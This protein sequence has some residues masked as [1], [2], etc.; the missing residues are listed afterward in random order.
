M[1]KIETPDVESVARGLLELAHT[2]LD[3]GQRTPEWT[4]GINPE[5]VRTTFLALLVETGELLQLFNWKPWKK[6][7]KMDNGRR[8]AMAEEF[9]DML[10]FFGYIVLW[11]GEYG[12][13]PIDLAEAYQKK[14]ELNKKRMSG[15]IPGYGV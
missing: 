12:L 14:T 15:I 10:A 6:P 7:V 3:I 9:A 8:D 11:L 13:T 5:Y 4:E 2:Q 1:A